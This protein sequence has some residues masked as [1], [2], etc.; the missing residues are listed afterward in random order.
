[1]RTTALKDKYT[2]EYGAV[3]AWGCIFSQNDGE[4]NEL[5]NEAKKFGDIFEETPTGPK[6]FL[7]EPIGRTIKVLKIRKPDPSWPERGDVDF[8][9]SNY[10]AFK[11]KHLNDKHF[12][13]IPRDTFEMIELTEPAATVR[14]YFSNPP[15]EKQ[16]TSFFGK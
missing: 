10:G 2:D 16:Y 6:F 1:M 12:K 11:E 5:L 9:V 13:L 4:Y 3:A 15:I 14:V 8:T 7:H